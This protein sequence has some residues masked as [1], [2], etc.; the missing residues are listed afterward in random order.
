MGNYRIVYWVKLGWYDIFDKSLRNVFATHNFINFE[1]NLLL[2]NQQEAGQSNEEEAGGTG[3]TEPQV[4][5]PVEEEEEKVAAEE[6]KV[7]EPEPE[8]EKEQEQAQP[9]PAPKQS[10]GANIFGSNV[11]SQAHTSVKVRAPPGGKSSITF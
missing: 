1:T 11:P 5:A 10:S 8:A 7:Q 4:E 2:E 6:V 3:G 9:T